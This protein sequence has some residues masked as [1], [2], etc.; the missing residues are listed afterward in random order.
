M[1]SISVGSR[2]ALALLLSLSPIFQ[3]ACAANDSDIENSQE[4]AQVQ[5]ENEAQ[6][7][8]MNSRDDNM[9]EQSS[10]AHME[11]AAG[12]I[13]TVSGDKISLMTDSG[14]IKLNISRLEVDDSYPDCITQGTDIIAYYF[15]GESDSEN[16]PFVVQVVSKAQYDEIAR[17]NGR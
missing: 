17:R 13:T 7:N 12:T 4:S 3:A 1:A 16:I 10:S 9:A 6:L 14:T 15:Q 11:R 2:T 8:D 5:M